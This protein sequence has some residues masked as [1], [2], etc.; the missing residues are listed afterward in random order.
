[1][2]TVQAHIVGYFNAPAATSTSAGTKTNSFLTAG[3]CKNGQS[4]G[5]PSRV[6]FYLWT[7]ANHTLAYRDLVKKQAIDH[8]LVCSVPVSRDNSW[9]VTQGAQSHSHVT[10]H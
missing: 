3:A 2:G 8:N 6:S 5:V 9:Q 10:P 1:M 7:P 4:K